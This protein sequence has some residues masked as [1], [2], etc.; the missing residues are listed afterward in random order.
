MDQ[1][2]ETQTTATTAAPVPA[3]PNASVTMEKQPFHFKKEKIRDEA[4]T[5]LGEGKKLPKAELYLPT[6]TPDYLVGVLTGGDDTSKERELLLTAVSSIIYEQARDQINSY[7]ESNKDVSEINQSALDLD[8]LL[9]KAIANMPRA[10]RAS[11]VPSDED[12]QIFFDSYKEI[13]PTA[14]GKDAAKITKHVE[15]FKEGFKRVRAQK[16][17]LEVFKDAIAVYCQHASTDA[18][19]DNADVIKYF[20]ARL[21]RMLNAESKVTLDDI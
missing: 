9:W 21:D 1:S 3:A 14:T 7:R 6:P 16:P 8:K 5:V 12:M 13:M 20:D 10:E 19:E 4:G 2:N 15:L 18:L 11:S 17:M